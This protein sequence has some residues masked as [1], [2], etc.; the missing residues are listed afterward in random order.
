MVKS[1]AGFYQIGCHILFDQS[2][3]KNKNDS[4]SMSEDK[5][6]EGTKTDSSDCLNL[7]KRPRRNRKSQAIRSL[8]QETVLRPC[9]LVVPF[10]LLPGHNRKEE[11][12]TLPGIYRLSADLILKEAERLHRLNIPAIALFPVI[13]K[14]E[15][16]LRAIAA[17]DPEGLVPSAV[18]YIKR[19]IPSICVITDIALDP[20]TSHGHDGLIDEKGEVLNDITIEMLAQ[21]SLL[22][23]QAGA[24]LVAPSDMMDG[25][26]GAIRT[27]LDRNFM[28]HVGILSYTAKYASSLYGPYRDA[29][30]SQLICGNKKSYQLNPANAREALLEAALDEEEGA[31]M[32]MVKPAL[33]YLDILSSLRKSTHLPLCAYHVSGEYAMVMAAHER[34]MLDATLVFHEALMSIKRAGADFIFSYAVP[35]VLPLL[36]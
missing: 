1:K 33:F 19:E 29:L 17:L 20:F 24:D 36:T 4:Q 30:G 8:V 13:P 34:G 22:H 3:E 10:F 14:E 5:N 32:L 15:K 35:Q 9:D 7:I 28:Q 6:F 21:I 25:R 27:V 12:P 31:D 18:Q 23:A 11:I 16:D 2:R 26:V